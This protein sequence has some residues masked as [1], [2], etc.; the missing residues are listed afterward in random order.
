M[1]NISMSLDLMRFKNAGISTLTSSKTGKAKRCVI[2]PI[3]DND[4][5]INEYGIPVN[6][7]GFPYD[8]KETQTHLIKQSFTKEKRDAMTEEQKKSL[9]ILGCVWKQKE[10]TPETSDSYSAP[11][12]FSNSADPTATAAVDD[13]PF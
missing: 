1:N 7:I 6:L 9:P 12:Q 11:Q 8:G 5:T 4:L 13:L 3:E 2:I 10:Y